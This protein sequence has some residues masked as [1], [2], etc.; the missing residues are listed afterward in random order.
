[1]L[2]ILT[3]LQQLRLSVLLPYVQ[4]QQIGQFDM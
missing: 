1:M 2:C 4:Q 3:H